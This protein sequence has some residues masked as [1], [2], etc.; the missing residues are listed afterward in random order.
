VSRI[1]VVG[2]GISGLGAAWLLAR[3]HDVLLFE[4]EPRLGGHTHTHRVDTPDGP[5]AVDTGF[6]VYNDR[7]YPL[8]VRLFDEIGLAR[9]D[10]DMSFGVSDTAT[11]FEY[12]T[13]TLGSLFA[14]RRTLVRP[15]HYRFLLEILRFNR[16]A[17][18][19]LGAPDVET[20]TLGDFCARHQF[21]GVVLD[22]YIAPL[23]CAI[24]SASPTAIRAFP[25]AT[26]A[27]F[28]ENHGML[29]TLDH[30]T[31]K[32]VCGG[33]ATYIPSLVASPRIAVHVASA[34]VAV[35]R[36]AGGARL[37]FE[38]RPPIDVEA[39][40]FA[41]HG[42]E[43]LPI[44]A[45]ASALERSV[46][47]AFGTTANRAVLHTDASFL[48]RRVAARAAWNYQIGAGTGATLTYDMNR[49]QRLKTTRQY[50][51]TL[52]PTRPIAPS[53][54][55]AEIDY[56]HPLYTAAAVRAQARWAEI[57]GRHRTHYCGAYWFYGFHEDGF[58]SAVRVAH[59][60]GVTW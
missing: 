21:D 2:G 7:T 48:P 6:I 33:S 47:S 26:L 51:V 31:W 13:R 44:L 43:V 30:P 35:V 57:S 18:R 23:A 3:Q 45:D 5:L 46:L 39:V 32:V 28:F 27:R 40:V 24:W 41:C 20:W 54:V 38:D 42:D 56:T 10:S 34:P 8:L 55:L 17:R 15:A 53:R 25:F 49:L 14:D 59:A 52:N 58:R 50:C 22:R 29:D 1:A 11:G 9:I 37:S 60:L 19:A 16:T 12:S 4:R 36:T